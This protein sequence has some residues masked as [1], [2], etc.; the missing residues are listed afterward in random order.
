VIRALPHLSGEKLRAIGGVEVLEYF[1]TAEA[2]QRL[3]T[4]AK[5]APGSRLT[6]AAKAALARLGLP[7][8]AP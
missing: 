2:T 8:T 1:G 4:L 3:E 6:E 5:G 7:K